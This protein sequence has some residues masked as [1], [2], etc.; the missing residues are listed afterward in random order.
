MNFVENIEKE[1][2][3]NFVSNHP[4][5][6]HFM[7]SY[8]WG[9]VQKNKNFKPYY[10]GLKKNNELVATA[11]ILEKKIFKNIGYLYCPRGFVTDYSNS[12]IVEKFLE[13][14]K[15]FTKRKKAIFLRLDPDITLN[16]LDDNANI[17]EEN[18]V[19][20][21]LLSLFPKHKFKHKGFNK[22]FENNQ[23]RYTFRL[24]LDKEW[25]TIYANFHPT[26]RKILNKKNPFSLI[27][28]KGTQS[29]LNPFYTTMLETSKRENIVPSKLE[30]YETFYTTLN[31]QN[32]SDIYIVK[33]NIKD[34][35]NI[36]KE[37]IETLGNEIIKIQ[38]NQNKNEEKSKQKIIDLE[39]QISKLKKEQNNIENIKEDEITLS[40]I[41]T[42]KY[43]DMVWTIHGGNHTLLRELNAN[44]LLYEQI[45]KDAHKDGYKKIDFFG[46]TGEPN[47]NNPVYGI[48]LFKK[49]L[50]GDYLEFIGEFDYINQ[51]LLYFLYT[52][53]LPKIRKKKKQ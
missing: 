53:V 30:Y 26:T 40:S 15:K 17:K 11:L 19:G 27:M 6:A 21:Y 5:K 23:P 38:N 7:Q 36:Y 41:I 45:I 51:K 48:Y 28:Y 32:M 31:A 18:P 4:T 25:E 47:E 13:E 9:E 14:L 50:G 39:K 1:E 44:Y 42:A 46:T 33:A 49:R 37:K 29:D 16:I 43:K 12:E 22:N 24:S 20:K 3:E 35:G 2:F 10:V 8:Y 34:L 52:K